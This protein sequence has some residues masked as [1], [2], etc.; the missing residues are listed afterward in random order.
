MQTP[1]GFFRRRELYGTLMGGNPLPK[2]YKTGRRTM[3]SRSDE[4]AFPDEELALNAGSLHVWR[5][6][7]DRHNTDRGLDSILTESERAA[8]ERYHFPQDRLRFCQRRAA[9][10]CI[11]GR[12]TGIKPADLEFRHGDYG[13]PFLVRSGNLDALNFSVSSSSDLAV[14]CV[15]QS[16][17]PGI[18]L[19]AAGGKEISRREANSVLRPAEQDVMADHAEDF[20]ET[21]LRFWTCKEA[22]LKAIGMGLSLGPDQIEVVG[23]RDATPQVSWIPEEHGP[24]SQWYLR[25][26]APTP[27]Y[28]C[29]T[30]VKE[31]QLT[32]QTWTWKGMPG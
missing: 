7:I 25:F 24:A 28:V 9:L 10:R 14:I 29:A 32:I 5:V 4:W 22:V 12:Y 1:R 13:K 19:E 3:P 21:F 6:R 2:F 15:A 11:L 8:A 17:K 18:D 26:L 16:L 31:R 23:V 20:H 30:A 27:G